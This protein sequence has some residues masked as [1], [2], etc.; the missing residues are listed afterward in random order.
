MVGGLRV[1]RPRRGEKNSLA[2]FLIMQSTDCFSSYTKNKEAFFT[3]ER[4]VVGSP[5]SRLE[6][7][8]Q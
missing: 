6:A 1:T 7:S 4:V 3:T 5:N 2:M 8:Q